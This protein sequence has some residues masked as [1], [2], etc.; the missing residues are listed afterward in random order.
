M[1]KFDNKLL[2]VFI[3]VNGVIGFPDN[4]PYY[5]ENVNHYINL[6]QY[7]CFFASYLGATEIWILANQSDIPFLKE[8]VGEFVRNIRKTRKGVYTSFKIP[9]FYVSESSVGF[10]SKNKFFAYKEL[11]N[12][13]S[14]FYAQISYY[15]I[16]QK[17]LLLHTENFFFFKD[18]KE[19][20]NKLK[21]YKNCLLKIE[22]SNKYLALLDRKQMN[23]LVKTLK[24]IKSLNKNKQTSYLMSDIVQN[25]TFENTTQINTESHSFREFRNKIKFF[26]NK[27]NKIISSQLS[28]RKYF[29]FV[30][31]KRKTSKYKNLTKIKAFKNI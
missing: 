25:Y 15:R 18:F 31:I 29:D 19:F 11:Y 2:P 13:V 27:N 8:F 5:L 9:I 7:Q 1:K 30:F 14:K 20:K 24:E 23:N 26:S 21:N 28:Q 10:I 16:P 4:I 12:I 6:L 17:F 3:P 22:N